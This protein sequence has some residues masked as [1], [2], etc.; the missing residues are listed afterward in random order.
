MTNPVGSHS[1]EANACRFLKQ[2]RNRADHAM[3][4]LIGMMFVT[5]LLLSLPF[6]TWHL[7]IGVGGILVM[8]FYSAKYVLP[9]SNYYQYVLSV[10]I[11]TFMVQYD[12]QLNGML[13]VEL[14][15]FLGSA[16]LAPYQNWK[17]QIPLAFMLFLRY[18]LFDNLKFIGM[19][20]A[21]FSHLM[22]MPLQ[23]MVTKGLMATA[24][25]VF[26]ALC[27]H[28]TKTSTLRHLYKSFENG[29]LQ[30]MKNLSR[31]KLLT[32]NA[33]A[34]SSMHRHFPTSDGPAGSARI[35]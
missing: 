16:M 33:D 26:A 23:P 24:I 29:Q 15:A 12:F 9:D 27:A 31:T 10:A 7:G 35:G 17:L 14:F 13:E 25:L 6:G 19:G 1:K 4:Y 2:L 20:R 3:N 21:A 8:A 5:G 22:Q 30:T 28:R 18:M 34:T 32:T 11:G